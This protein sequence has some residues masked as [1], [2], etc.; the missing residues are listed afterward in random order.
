MKCLSLF[1]LFKYLKDQEDSG[2]RAIIFAHLSTGCQ[3]CHEKLQWLEM[4]ISTAAADQSFEFSEETIIAIVARFK[5]QAAS[6][7]RPIRQYIARLI[8]DSGIPLQLAEARLN[9][10]K[11]LVRRMLYNAEGYDIDLKFTWS[12]KSNDERLAGQILSERCDAIEPTQFKVELLQHASVISAT[13]TDKHG[14]FKFDRLMP[15]TYDLKVS[16]P[17]GEINLERVPTARAL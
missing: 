7:L 12:N 6:G 14:V 5:Q 13:T 11:P 2:E 17:N 10:E 8:F 15:G 16:V 1:V 9:K 3:A 4:T